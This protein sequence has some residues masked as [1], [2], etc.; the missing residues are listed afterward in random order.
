LFH[1]SFG[2]FKVLESADVVVPLAG[3]ICEY[4]FPVFDE[5]WNDFM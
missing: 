4:R 2:L 3:Q 1:E 5:L